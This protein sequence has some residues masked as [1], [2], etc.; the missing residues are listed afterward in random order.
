MIVGGCI[1]LMLFV[2][3]IYYSCMKPKHSDHD[4]QKQE[5][6]DKVAIEVYGKLPST[7]P[8]TPAPAKAVV[9]ASTNQDDDGFQLVKD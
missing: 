7:L 4:L 9:V 1:P 6:L 5:M 3:P 8:A 2:K